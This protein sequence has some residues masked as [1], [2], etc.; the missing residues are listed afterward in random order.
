MEALVDTGATHSFVS[1][2]SVK[3]FHHK[4]ESNTKPCKVMNSTVVSMT[5]IVRSTPLRVGE[6]FGNMDVFVYPLDDLGVG[7]P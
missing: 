3:S 1:E 2:R 4:P 5:G 7:I 6:W